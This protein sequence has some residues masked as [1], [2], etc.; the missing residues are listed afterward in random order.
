[1]CLEQNSPLSADQQGWRCGLTWHVLLSALPSGVQCQSV[2]SGQKGDVNQLPE[3]FIAAQKKKK[4]KIQKIPPNNKAALHLAVKKYLQ[5][6]G[7]TF[8]QAL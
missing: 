3:I 5:S 1:M 6:A 7:A 2:T 4:K 8:Q